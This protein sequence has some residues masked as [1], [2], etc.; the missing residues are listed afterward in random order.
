MLVA[1]CS[2]SLSAQ[3]IKESS[4]SIS[5]S[6]DSTILLSEKSASS[7]KIFSHLSVG[8]RASTMGGG[9]EVATPLSNYFTLRG[10][11]NFMGYKTST[12]DLGLDD[13]NGDFEEAFGYTPDYN[14]KGELNFTNGHLLVDF[15]PTKGIF[16]LTAGAFIG[17]NRLK[18]NGLLVDQ[19]GNPAEL[20]PGKKWPTVDFD[21]HQL[22]LDGPNLDAT[23]QLGQVIKPYFGLGLGRAVAKNNRVSFK[24][25]LGLIYQGNYSLKQNGKKLDVSATASESFEDFDTYTNLLKW[26]PMLNFQLSY[27]IF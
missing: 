16:H 19:Y 15:Y 21:G 26:W 25:E 27:R 18:A 17:A 23:L 7:S 8:L 24:F 11:L 1:S 9:I 13:P 2:L 14:M 3:E 5:T 10:G 4:D 12:F 22:V 6:V 20:L